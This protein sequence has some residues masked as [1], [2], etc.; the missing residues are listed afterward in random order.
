MAADPILQQF[1]QL[2]VWSRGDQC[3][4]HKQLLVLYALGRW[5]QGKVEVTYADAEPDLTYFAQ[6]ATKPGVFGGV[7]MARKGRFSRNTL[8][9]NRLWVS[10]T[11]KRL[12]SGAKPRNQPHFCNIVRNMG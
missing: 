7:Q 5:Q 6:V 4:P 12:F 2:G 11:Q 10:T 9:P 8:T 3:A 1:D